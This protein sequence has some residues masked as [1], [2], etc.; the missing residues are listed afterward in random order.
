MYHFVEP[1]CRGCERILS[2]PTAKVLIEK[3]KGTIDEINGPGVWRFCG[4]S[5]GSRKTMR[6]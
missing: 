1:F 3:A 5:V 6:A 4:R 2:G